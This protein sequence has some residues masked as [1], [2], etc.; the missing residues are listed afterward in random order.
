LRRDVALL[1][2]RQKNPFFQH[3]EASYFLAERDAQVVGRIAAIANRLHNETHGDLVGFFGFFE[4]ENRQ[5][6]ADALFAAAADWLKARG[7]DTMRGPASF[8]VNDECGLLVDGFDT[9]PALMMPHNPRYYQALIEQA[10][11]TGARNLLVYQGGDPTLQ[12]RRAAPERLSRAV[13]IMRE[14]MGITVRPLDLKRFDD[15][16]EAIKR[17]YNAAWEKNWGFVPMTEAEIDHLARQFKPVVMPELVGMAEKDGEVIGFGLG[18]PDLN[19]V[20]R[21]NRG[22]YLLPVLPRLLWALKTGKI[23]RIRIPLLGILPAYRGKGLDAVLYHYIWSNGQRIGMRWGEAGWILED[24]TAMNLG[25]EK[26][27]FHVYK[28]YRLYDRPL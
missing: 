8:S 28:T 27:D 21:S 25:L 10:G 24:N 4:C 3:A 11:F 12:E 7:F 6:T 17:I 1:L 20:F 23:H 26:M 19:Q 9:P 5:D 18:L 16:V 15:E 13:G 14:R 22:G 2:N